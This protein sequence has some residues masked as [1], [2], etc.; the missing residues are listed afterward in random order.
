MVMSES[1]GACTVLLPRDSPTLL[2]RFMIDRIGSDSATAVSTVWK[3]AR[4]TLPIDELPEEFCSFPPIKLE[5]PS[6]PLLDLLDRVSPRSFG[7]R[8]AR[9]P[10]SP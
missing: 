2:V 4:L 7:K 1:T 10:Q 3:A 6:T 8:L 9:I 5:K